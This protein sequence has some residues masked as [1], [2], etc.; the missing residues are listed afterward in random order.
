[1]AVWQSISSGTRLLMLLQLLGQALSQASIAEF[2]QR[3]CAAYQH[4]HAQ[5]VEGY[6]QQ[7]PDGF[8]VANVLRRVTEHPFHA[9]S[10]TRP[11]PRVA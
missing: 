7:F 2:L 6:M 4:T 3:D 5:L 11:V 1:M 8:S 9:L 10:H